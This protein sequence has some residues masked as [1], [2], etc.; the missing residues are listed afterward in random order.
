MREPTWLFLPA[1]LRAESS[2]CLGIRPGRICGGVLGGRTLIMISIFQAVFLG[3]EGRP[4]T[5]KSTPRSGIEGQ[6][7]YPQDLLGLH[8]RPELI[9]A[10]V[11][12]HLHI[13][14]EEEHG[15]RVPFS[16]RILHPH[17]QNIRCICDVRGT[18]EKLWHQLPPGPGALHWLLKGTR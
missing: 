18:R 14:P 13:S 16:R 15:S 1:V 4:K 7:Q 10:G 2:L 9:L 6:C 8:Q 3:G 12:G 17:H 5:V 11:G